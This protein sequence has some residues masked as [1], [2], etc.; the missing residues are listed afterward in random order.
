MN[1]PRILVA[2]AWLAT[3]A[4][5]YFFG[6]SGES[7]RHSTAAPPAPTPVPTVSA[8]AVP[9]TAPGGEASREEVRSEKPSVASLIARA[10]LEMR[11][12]Q[13]GM[14]NSRGMLR[15]MA[16]LAELD[17]AQLQEALAEV[18]QS[19]REAGQKQ[20]LY[21]A[22]LGLWAETDGRAAMAYAQGKLGKGSRFAGNAI[23]AVVGAWAR[24]DPEAVWKWFETQPKD[25]VDD[26]TRGIAATSV[27]RGMAAHDLESALAR[28]L[29][30][31]DR[32][33]T[34]ALHGIAD[35][36]T[37]NA[38]R[39]RL[40]DR[41]ASLP[42]GQRDKIRDIVTPEWALSA[43]DEVMA[44]IRSLPADEQKSV[45]GSASDDLLH[46]KPALAADFLLEGAA[47]KDKRRI[48][49][50]TVSSWAQEDVRAA[51]EWLTKQPQGPELDDAR[52]RYAGLVAPRDPAAAMDWAR[53]VQNEKQRTQS[54]ASVYGTWR[55][56]DP[57]A[58]N[59]ALRATGLP[60]E[61]I[62]QLVQ[63][64]PQP[65]GSSGTGTLML[66]VP[67]TAGKPEGRIDIEVEGIDLGGA[68]F[69][70]TQ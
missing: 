29:T 34:S 65:P 12:G 52:S 13:P 28:L 39:R 2:A 70:L 59:A 43:P 18:E 45:R 49:A 31:D 19:V 26:H 25:E 11:G 24:R 10:R 54:I 67:A 42:P 66:S 56:K 32:S 63:K 35:S 5:A 61:T 51:G 1:T 23:Q 22:L 58:A 57:A 60:P 47:E 64:P 46:A 41:S 62:N 40:L 17:D 68:K 55:A 33:R 36:A 7:A 20:M 4:V 38:S 50:R 53:S 37:D 14:R 27:F 48:L 30:I 16:A 15:A 44:W 69:I 6:S 21:S 8:D 9:V 3:L